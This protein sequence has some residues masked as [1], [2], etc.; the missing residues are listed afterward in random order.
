MPADFSVYRADVE[1][2]PAAD[3]AEHF[4]EVGVRQ[5]PAAAIVDDDQMKLTRSGKETIFPQTTTVADIA[6]HVLHGPTHGKQAEMDIV[7]LEI[8]NSSFHTH[9]GDM[10][11]GQGCG[12]TDVVK[13][14]ML[15]TGGGLS[16]F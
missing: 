2:G 16:R 12:H 3:T 8:G 14:M 6:G 11:P 9:E 7:I 4:L 1:T 10:H 13:V 15:P 5:N